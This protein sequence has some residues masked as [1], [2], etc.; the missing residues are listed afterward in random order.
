MG[1][2]EVDGFL[3]GVDA[4]RERSERLEA[5]LARLQQRLQGRGA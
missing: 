1:P 2:G 4:L 3:D 5:R